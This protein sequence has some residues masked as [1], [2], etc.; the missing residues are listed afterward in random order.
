M[1]KEESDVMSAVKVIAALI[2]LLT[3][4]ILKVGWLYLALRRRSNKKRKIFRKTM[5]KEGMDKETIEKL[6]SEMEDI[7]LRD[8]ISKF[9]DSDTSIPFLSRF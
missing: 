4:L 1:T 5:K 8:I 7:S 3:P 9:R 2:L 6:L